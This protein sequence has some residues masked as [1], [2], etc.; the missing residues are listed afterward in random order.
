M[1]RA[2]FARKTKEYVALH[3]ARSILC[4]ELGATAGL[5]HPDGLGPGWP[6]SAATI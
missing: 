2:Y 3:A 6:L 1:T 5:N 4:A